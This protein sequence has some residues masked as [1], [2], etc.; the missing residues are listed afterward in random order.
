M[1]DIVEAAVQA[2]ADEATQTKRLDWLMELLA[3]DEAMKDLIDRRW[4]RSWPTSVKAFSPYA[5]W[6]AVVTVAFYLGLTRGLIGIRPSN[7]IDLEYLLYLPFCCAFSTGDRIQGKLA[8]ALCSRLGCTFI[9]KDAL[10]ADL[11]RIAENWDGLSDSERQEYAEERG[12]YPPDL[13]GSVTT[14]LWQRT[15]RPWTPGSGNRVSRMTEEE[16]QQLLDFLR[17]IQE[18]AEKAQRQLPENE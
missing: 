15:M 11:A 16:K 8:T 2:V 18:A 7:R 1:S 17:P 13:P 4:K 10:K 14:E 3:I 5:S 9:P 12:P 6:I